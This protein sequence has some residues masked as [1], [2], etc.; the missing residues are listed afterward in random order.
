MVLAVLQ[1]RW[2]RS[3]GMMLYCYQED[4]P[5]PRKNKRR[6]CGH[7]EWGGK[8]NNEEGRQPGV[9]AGKT[10]DRRTD[11]WWTD[12]SAWRWSGKEGLAGRTDTGGIR[13]LWKL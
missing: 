4:L 1:A 3:L 10:A 9:V 11:L 13:E 8:A 5:C 2:L 6:E 12:L 7:F